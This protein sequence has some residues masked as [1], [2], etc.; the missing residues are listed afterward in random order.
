MMPRWVVAAVAATWLGVLA[1]GARAVPIQ[2]D[3]LDSDGTGFFDPDLGGA[4]RAALE[5]AVNQWA[6]TLAG[7]VPIVVAAR[8]VPLGG[9]GGGALLASSGAT[10]VHRNFESGIPDTWY[11]AAL[12]NELTGS[13]LN[14]PGTPEI[15][16][17]FNSDVDGPSVLGSLHWYYGLD[18]APGAD[19]DFVTIALHE[20]G[21]GLGFS[22]GIDPTSGRLGD[23]RQPGD[24]RSHAR[25]AGGGMVRPDPG[26]GAALGG[27]HRPAGWCG[28]RRTSSGSSAAPSRSIPPIPFRQARASATGTRASSPTS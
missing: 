26:G 16:T 22:G 8:M 28:T 1:T 13:D 21:H 14:G 12:A 10:T 17:T 3:Y 6:D 4:R 2:V 25:A 19:F 23:R 27:D 18:A 24:L 5:A 15:V 11:V 20:L 9:S 7:N